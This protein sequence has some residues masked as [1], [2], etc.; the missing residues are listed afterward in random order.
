MAWR[1]ALMPRRVSRPVLQS[2]RFPSLWYLTIRIR[3]KVKSRSGSSSKWKVGPDPHP[4]KRMDPNPRWWDLDSN[5]GWNSV[6]LGTVL[7][8]IY[9][10]LWLRFFNKLYFILFYFILFYSI[11]F[12][13]ILFYSTLFYSTILYST[14]SILLHLFYSTPFYS[15][16]FCS[17]LMIF[18]KVTV[19]DE[20][21]L[22]E[23]VARAQANLSRRESLRLIKVSTYRYH[24]I[25]IKIQ[26]KILR[27]VSYWYIS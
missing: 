2:C 25:C 14:Y 26:S 3:I 1:L 6:L 24:E 5:T 16:L 23:A 9:K 8:R 21:S 11:L 22:P 10:V 12:Y 17:I 15:I 19:S 27:V 20:L 18:C 4:R 7:S 13:S